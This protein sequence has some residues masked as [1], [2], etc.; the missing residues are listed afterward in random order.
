MR[1][2]QLSLGVLILVALLLGVLAGLSFAQG[3]QPPRS[4]AEVAVGTAFTYQGRLE[5]DGETVD[6]ECEFQFTLHDASELGS[7]VG[8]TQTESITVPDRDAVSGREHPVVIRRRSPG[9]PLVSILLDI[10]WV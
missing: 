5:S 9:S 7:Q 1:W 3:P 2:Q 10:S 8:I 4:A 6:D